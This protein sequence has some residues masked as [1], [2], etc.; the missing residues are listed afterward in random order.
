MTVSEI[1]Q[2]E[3]TSWFDRPITAIIPLNWETLIFSI[4]IIFAII[5]RFY[6][7][8]ARV[9]SHDENSHVYFSWLY[10][11]GNGYTH[12][13]VTHGPFQFHIIALT[14]FLFG[15]NDFTARVP[16][17]LFGVATIA[18]MWNYRRLLGRI[19]AL[20]AAFLI[21]ISPYI[22]FYSR[23]ARNE[24]FIT[25]FAVITLWAVLR[26]LESGKKRYLYWFTFAIVMHFVSKE[27][28]YIYTAQALLFLAF[29]L[30]YQLSKNP[31]QNPIYRNRFL[32][33]LIIGLIL[34]G[35]A[36]GVLLVSKNGISPT[37][38]ETITPAIPGQAPLGV[39]AGAMSPIVLLLAGL[40]GLAFIAVIYFVLRGY[41]WK[42]LCRERSFDLLILLGTLILPLLAAFPVKLLGINSIDYQSSQTIFF[43]AAFVILFAIIGIAIGL[44]WDPRLWLI[45]AAIFYSIFTV[46][47]TS[48]FT[49][50]FGF[51]TG[52]VGALGYW[53]EQQAVNR[54]SQPWYYYSLLQ[55]PFYEFLP[56]LGTFLALIFAPV[57]LKVRSPVSS[58]SDE[59]EESIQT[60]PVTADEPPEIQ[61]DQEDRPLPGTTIAL[62]LFWSY[63]SLIAFSIA[64]EK[65]PWLT[66]HIT[67]GMI[68][69]TAWFLGRLADS[70]DWNMFSRRRGILVLLLI[71]VFLAS[72]IGV[73]ATLLG[74]NPPFQGKE[75]IELQATSTFLLSGITA[76]VS[77]WGLV[78]LTRPW[79]PGQFIRVLTLVFFAFL[80]F[81]TTRSAIMASYIYYDYAKE[82][83]VYAH[84]APGD[85]EALAQ[86]EEISRRT[87]D[88]LGLRVAYDSDTSYPFWW[89]LRDYPNK[90]FYGKEPTRAL[91]QD[92]VI[93]VG[94]ENFDK[95]E[96]VVGQAY[97]RFDYIRLWWPNQDYFSLTP[98]R[99]IN[100]LKNPEMRSALL[101]IWLDRDYSLYGTLTNKDMSSQ[102]WYPSSKMRLY[103]RKDIISSLWNYG[104]S[105]SPQAAIA[106]PYEGKQINLTADI[107]LGTAGSEPG[108]FKRQRD[109]AVAPDG[110]LY[111]ADTEN[112]RI[113]HLSAD[114]KVLQ[115]WGSYAASTETNPAPGGTFNEPWGIAVG[116][117]GSVYVADTWNNRIQKF[118]P[119]GNFVTSWGYGIS[120]SDDPFGFYGPRDV[121]VSLD[122]KVFVTDTGNKRVD[123]FDA[124]GK[125]IT[126]FG[127]AGLNPGEFDEPVGIAVDKDGLV[128][129]ADTWNQRIQVF[130]LASD[131]SYQP[132][133]SWEI[134]GWYGQSLDNK[135][136]IAVD[137]DGHIYVADPEA[138]RILEFTTSGQFLQ[139]WGDY[140]TGSDGFGLAGSVAVDQNGNVWVSD[141]NNNRLM[142]FTIPT[143]LVPAK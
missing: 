6:I 59:S 118:D 65:M 91:R 116:P 31:W 96:P 10:E 126:K 48:V 80:S 68:L 60:A 71:P 29:Y 74:V 122:G 120:Q 138:N 123:V 39:S 50:G 20:I 14:Y 143:N 9:M 44:V 46:L 13:P 121:A 66:V 81:L 5:S 51:M 108:Q 15:D 34:I 12:D 38:A 142:H 54:G 104:V 11:Q 110:T 115:V 95:I 27:T 25:L 111:V 129:V 141:T 106:D 35:A 33:A 119:E 101:K 134:A 88:G 76:I 69:C 1:E 139:F 26:Y 16:A 103:I 2:E 131:G 49:N 113:Q 8:G 30:V 7:L 22:L 89:Y 102:N 92:A 3:K 130:T 56:Y 97:D 73:F 133:N 32:V 36:G 55:L 127:G 63:S 28:A 43:D 52:L 77:G 67:L 90:D 107:I 93:L 136:Y 109:L 24:S 86:I 62:L 98:T 4:I 124:D 19:G 105:P 87:T 64:G 114:G 79:L 84:S 125:F 135:P 94:E 42:G 99:I 53:M 82:F 58:V 70:T 57:L 40:G 23:Y 75:L 83:L 128:Y 72:L 41:T 21:L 117:D 17:A 100:V 85:K 137:A 45:N 112:H 18:F 132:L 37:G 61:S 47:Y 140:S 78:K